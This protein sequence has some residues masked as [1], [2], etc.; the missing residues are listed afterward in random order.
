MGAAGNLRSMSLPR[1]A[2]RHDEVAAS[3]A[4]SPTLFDK[5]VREGRMPKG[6]K[7]GG[8]VLWDTQEVYDHWIA[9]RDGDTESKNPFDGNIV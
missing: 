2:L 7:I 5:W 3:V 9:L 4:V 8:V 6:R 1:F